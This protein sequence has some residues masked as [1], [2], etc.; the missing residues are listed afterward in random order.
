MIRGAAIVGGLAVFKVRPGWKRTTP[1]RSGRLMTRVSS[2]S[3]HSPS[4]FF[5]TVTLVSSPT[6]TRRRVAWQED[7]PRR[8]AGPRQ[9]AEQPRHIGVRIHG[10][11]NL[12]AKPRAEVVAEIFTAIKERRA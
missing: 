11:G 10:K 1:V 3:R 2:A 8:D 5:V 12:G 6:F 4:A 7:H 9:P